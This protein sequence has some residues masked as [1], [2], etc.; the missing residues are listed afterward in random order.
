MNFK[1]LSYNLAYKNY[2]KNVYNI[3]IAYGYGMEKI[4]QPDVLK[5]SANITKGY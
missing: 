3:D 1:I 4:H 5:G 2:L